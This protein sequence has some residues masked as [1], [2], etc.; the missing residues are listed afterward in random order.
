M[1]HTSRPVAAALALLGL[2]FRGATHGD[3]GRTYRR[4]AA[5]THPDAGGSTAAFRALAA[6]RE[7]LEPILPP[8]PPSVTVATPLRRRGRPALL[9]TDRGDYAPWSGADWTGA[10]SG[11]AWTPTPPPARRRTRR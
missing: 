5:A 10:G 8:G 11:L 3:L 1:T 4:L 9:V 2:P 7:L 6:A